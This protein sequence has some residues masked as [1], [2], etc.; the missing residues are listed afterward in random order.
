[1]N[2]SPALPGSF[3]FQGLSFQGRKVTAREA[4]EGGE[5]ETDF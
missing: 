4:R 2:K 1:V 3:Q 5:G